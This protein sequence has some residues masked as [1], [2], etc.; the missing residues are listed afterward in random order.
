MKTVL[1]ADDN[2][3]IIELLQLILSKSGYRL[4]VARGGK[5]ALDLCLKSPPDM[6]LLDLKMADMD[7]F[8]VIRTLREKGFSRPIIVL[9]GSE[10]AD[11][12][13]QAFSAGCDEYVLKTMEMRD[14]ELT[15]DK[16]LQ[17]GGQSLT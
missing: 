9:T 12:R 11:D 3:D 14:L 8:T 6:L 4:E 7:G 2:E 13:S 16:Y 17:S 1:L 15:M 5:Q 10:S